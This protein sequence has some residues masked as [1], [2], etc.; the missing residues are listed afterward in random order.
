QAEAY[1]HLP[2]PAGEVRGQLTDAVPEDQG[3][4]TA[5]DAS[6]RGDGPGRLAQYL[7]QVIDGSVDPQGEHALKLESGLQAEFEAEQSLA[8]RGAGARRR[9]VWGQRPD[10]E[11]AFLVGGQGG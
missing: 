7:T 9:W 8:G 11:G 1:R 5:A 6:G 4:R 10:A 3:L 2:G